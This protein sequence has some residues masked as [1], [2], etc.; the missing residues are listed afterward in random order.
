MDEAIEGRF[1]PMITFFFAMRQKERN[2]EDEDEEEKKKD[3]Q[4]VF[5]FADKYCL[6]VQSN[7][8]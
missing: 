8:C 3:K 6:V 1:V 4:I 5:V 2:K 7:V